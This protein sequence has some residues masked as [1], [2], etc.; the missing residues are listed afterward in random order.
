MGHAVL[1]PREV[2]LGQEAPEALALQRASRQSLPA[3]RDSEWQAHTFAGAILVPVATLHTPSD[4]DTVRLADVYD[5]SVPLI[6]SHL[7]R[8]RKLLSPTV[9]R[10]RA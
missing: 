2:K 9:R 4:R 5:V 7:R 6:T 1:H 10:P 8:C 3:F